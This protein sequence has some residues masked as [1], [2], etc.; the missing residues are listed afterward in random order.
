MAKKAGRPPKYN[1]PEIPA[2]LDE[3]FRRMS[4]GESL[5]SIT[6]DED[7]FGCP[8]A[9]TI[10][11]WVLND[12]PKGIAAQYAKARELQYESWSDQ[13]IDHADKPLIGQK[14][15]TTAEGGEEITEGDCVD[16]ARLKVDA[17][18]WILSKLAPKKYG[19]KVEV[20]TTLHAGDSLTEMMLKVRQQQ[21]PIIGA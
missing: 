4:L 1:D 3:V 6:Q 18:K 9:P 11:L 5:L 21:N 8:P 14:R 2:I 19:D 7:D 13:I 15:K 16:R 20:D 10:R 17:R 12:T